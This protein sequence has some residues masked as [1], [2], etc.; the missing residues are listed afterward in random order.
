VAAYIIRR[1]FGAL[2]LL[3]VVSAVTFAIFFLVPRL[4]GQTATP[5]ATQ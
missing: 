5:L 2:V 3:L 4:G 1:V